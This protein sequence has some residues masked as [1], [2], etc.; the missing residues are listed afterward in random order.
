MKA[1]RLRSRNAVNRT[2]A[3]IILER[4]EM[5]FSFGMAFLF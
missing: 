4:K 1:P 5:E 2:V 3:R